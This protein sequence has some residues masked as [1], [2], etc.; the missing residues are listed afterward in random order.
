MKTLLKERLCACVIPDELSPSI[1]KICDAAGI[2]PSEIVQIE[3]NHMGLNNVSFVIS[4]ESGSW[5][6][7]IPG[8]DTE[9]YSDRKAE[10]AAYRVLNP[11]DL[12]EKVLFLEPDTGLKLSVF[13]Q[14]ARTVDPFSDDDLRAAMERLRELHALPIRFSRKDSHKERL[15]RYEA[16][17]VSAGVCFADEFSAYLEAALDALE[18]FSGLA[19]NIVPCHGDYLSGNVL[20]QTGKKPVLIDWEF[21]AMGDAFEDIGS[22]CHH[23][24]FGP[25]RTLEALSFYLGRKPSD[26]EVVKIFLCCLS[27]GAL[28]YCWGMRR[29]SMTPESAVYRH[30]CD[31][32]LDC[33]RVYWAALGLSK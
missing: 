31:M 10:A 3:Q 18:R 25:E 22:F 11:F 7:R 16:L 24:E 4:A 13:Y 26:D 28:W 33:C 17:A 2:R 6:F 14:D 5:I 21:A 19:R 32:S 12:A 20:I 15:I 1:M 8:R 23:S 29:L 30:Y 27:S 9:L